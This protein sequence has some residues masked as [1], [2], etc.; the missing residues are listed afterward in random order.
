MHA[1][2]SALFVE[3]N[4]QQFGSN[5]EYSNGKNTRLFE[6]EDIYLHTATILSILAKVILPL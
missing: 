2:L 5:E 6:G 3:K 1:D 4:W